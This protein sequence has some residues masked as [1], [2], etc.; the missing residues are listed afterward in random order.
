[1][2]AFT[3]VSRHAFVA[4]AAAAVIIAACAN[5]MEPAQKAIASIESAVAAAG[6]DAEKY[7]PEQVAAVK[8]G[9]QGLKAAFDKKDYKAVITGAPALLSQAQGL[10]AAAAA[11][12]DE[13]MAALNSQWTQFASDLPAAVGGIQA[14]I[15]ELSK[16]KTLPQGV[17]KAAVESANAG[18]AEAQTMWNEATASFSA[19]SLEDAIAKAGAVKAKVGELMSALGMTTPAA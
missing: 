16:A 12:K 9:V 13:V 10:A 2:R 7:I 15:D 14:R 3:R 4:V 19:G 11:K 6:A 5:Q 18:L 8:S 17:D 1:M